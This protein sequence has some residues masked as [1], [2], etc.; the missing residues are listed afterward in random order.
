MNDTAKSRLMVFWILW[1]A[2]QSGIFVIYYFLGGSAP[3]RASGGSS[4][5]L[6][7]A[8]P[9]ALSFI[10]R[11]LVLT[12]IN[13]AWVALPIFIIGIALSE[14]SCFLGLFIFPAHKMELFLMSAFGIFQYLP[15]FAGRLQD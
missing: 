1:F 7:G 12:R 14:A 9:F 3:A 5:W 11:W 13:T 4:L 10:V 2:F 6:L 8:I 15:W